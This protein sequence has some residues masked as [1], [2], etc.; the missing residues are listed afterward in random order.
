MKTQKPSQDQSEP[1][2][3]M[4]PWK[5]ILAFVLFVLVVFALTLFFTREEHES[6]TY[7]GFEFAQVQQGAD[8]LWVTQIQVRGQLYNIPFYY[9]PSEVEDV[10]FEEGLADAIVDNPARPNMVYIAFDPDAGSRPVVGGVEISRLL[11]T[12][13][14]LLNMNVQSALTRTDNTTQVDSPIKTCA[15]AIDGVLVIVYEQSTT[16]AIVHEGNCVRMQYKTPEDSIRVSDR[17]AYELLKIM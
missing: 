8:T 9:H 2:S 6:Y 15:D 17:F 13:Y 10:L 12:R 4:T 5:F 7:N 11:G 16:N 3:K 14:N 1:E